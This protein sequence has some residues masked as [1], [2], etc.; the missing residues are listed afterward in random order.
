M[1]SVTKSKE[2]SFAE[3]N[4]H[5]VSKCSQSRSGNPVPTSVENILQAQV[6]NH[7]VQQLLRALSPSVDHKQSFPFPSNR[8][9]QRWSI[10]GDHQALTLSGLEEAKI[11]S[12][13]PPIIIQMLM[14]YS[15]QMD[16]TVPELEFN[17]FGWTIGENHERL[18]DHYLSNYRSALHHGEAGCYKYPK[19]VAAEIN[20]SLQDQYVQSARS[21]FNKGDNSG[22]LQDLGYALHI[23]QD[24]GAHGE[25]G[26]GYGHDKPK[27]DAYAPDNREKNIDGWNEA[28][29]NSADVV[30]EAQDFVTQL[31]PGKNESTGPLPGLKFEVPVPKT[32]SIVEFIDKHNPISFKGY[33]GIE[34]KAMVY[35]ITA[36][37]FGESILW[38]MPANDMEIIRPKGQKKLEKAKTYWTRCTNNTV[39]NIISYYAMVLHIPANEFKRNAKALFNSD[40]KL[41]SEILYD[42]VTRL[43]DVKKYADLE[44]GL[45]PIHYPD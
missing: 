8:C 44:L 4:T 19:N 3:K 15:T 24:R 1:K 17:I 14:K 34:S 18:V 16:L 37:V 22:A 41:M 40:P 23:A 27:T 10:G 9:I 21:C 36:W 43:H 39:R 45:H 20:K 33:G 32:G 30:D 42:H 38:E 28:V 35:A 7:A 13:M 29:C 31:F 12:E 11:M 25:G 26:I 2:V 6:G 5:G